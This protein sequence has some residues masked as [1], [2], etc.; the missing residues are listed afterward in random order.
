VLPAVAI[1]A[2]LCGAGSATAVTLLVV[3]DG[4]PPTQRYEVRVSL[5][6]A[7]TAEQKA[8]VES[9]LSA[10]YPTGT[11]RLESREEAYENFK[12]VYKDAPDLV[13]TVAPSSLPESFLVTTTANAFDCAVLSP[14]ERMD[15]VEDVRVRRLADGGRPDA[16]ILGCP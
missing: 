1:A 15:G 8:A 11:V 16:A 7:A 14:V 2:M 4:Q 5:N 10:R 13:R 12:E 6:V 3:R 9:D